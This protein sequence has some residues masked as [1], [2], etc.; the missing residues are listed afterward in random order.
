MI[1]TIGEVGGRLVD[2]E[3]AQQSSCDGVQVIGVCAGAS[4]LPDLSARAGDEAYRKE[5]DVRSVS[6]GHGQ[7]E[8]RGG[9]QRRHTRADAGPAAPGLIRLALWALRLIW[10]T[11]SAPQDTLAAA[12][13]VADSGGFPCQRLDTQAAPGNAHRIAV[14]AGA[15]TAAVLVTTSSSVVAVGCAPGGV[16]LVDIPAAVHA[17]QQGVVSP[18]RLRAA[19]PGGLWRS[20]AHHAPPGGATGSVGALA[21]APCG[22]LIAYSMQ[23]RGGVV[24]LDATTGS[25]TRVQAS[26]RP[27]RTIA[28]SQCGSYMLAGDCSGT[29]HVWLTRTWVCSRLEASRAS[30]GV[31]HAVWGPGGARAAATVFVAYEGCRQLACMR[32]S[33]PPSVHPTVLS[34]PLSELERRDAPGKGWPGPVVTGLALSEDGTRLAVALGGDHPA[35]GCVALW[36]VSSGVTV[37]PSF[38]GYVSPGPPDA[39]GDLEPIEALSFVGGGGVLSALHASGRVTSYPIA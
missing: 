38:V 6:V 11:I 10:T 12:L 37:R 32:L 31:S 26:P 1:R 39:G 28:W 19:K 18:S 25:Q 13:G 29:T 34:L 16:W 21:W 8:A 20:A 3:V 17:P 15:P 9:A 24:V 33:G 30:G 27:A 23:G 7:T 35:R 22:G 36:A 4:V 2:V 5:H 14:V